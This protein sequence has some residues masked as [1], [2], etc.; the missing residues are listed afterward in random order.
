MYLIWGDHFFPWVTDLHKMTYFIW[1]AV[2]LV[3]FLFCLKYKSWGLLLFFNLL[4]AIG[5]SDYAGKIVKNHY[6]R[7]RPFENHQIVCQQKSAAGSK[8]F[9][10]NHSSNM[11]TFATYTAQFIPGAAIPVYL[12]ATTV[13]YSRIYNG[14][15]YPSDVLAGGLAGAL[16]GLMFSMFSKRILRNFRSK[17]ETLL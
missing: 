8:S 11:F 2:P 1:I 7:L 16:W 13:A 12:I 3:I 14:V 15:H 17:K 9:Y 5:W 4:L 6:L 10:S